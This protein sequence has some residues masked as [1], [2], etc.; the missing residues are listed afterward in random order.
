MMTLS[1]TPSHTE[2]D[3]SVVAEFEE[4]GYPAPTLEDIHFDMTRDTRSLWNTKLFEL[5]TVEFLR[6]EN[7]E[8]LYLLP[9]VSDEYLDTLI[10]DRF[11]RLKSVWTKGAAQICIDGKS[12]S[13]TQIQSQINEDRET[14]LK[15]VCH[16]KRCSNVYAFMLL[17]NFVDNFF[18][19]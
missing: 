12:E 19:N 1:I 6:R 18:R 16:R 3:L 2:A 8:E 5:P 4:N 10:V 15:V 17:M 7:E 14:K 9:T 11:T 13:Q